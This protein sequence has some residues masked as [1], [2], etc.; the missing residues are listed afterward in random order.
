[1]LSPPVPDFVQIIALPA[2]TYLQCNFLLFVFSVKEER[3]FKKK[4]HFKSAPSIDLCITKT[5]MY[6]V[7]MKLTKSPLALT[8]IYLV[9]CIYKC[10]FK[11]LWADA[12][13]LLWHL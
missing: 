12:F 2:L 4:W 8:M 7:E 5:T 11:H 9:F 3:N 1:M 13:I 6:N 10:L